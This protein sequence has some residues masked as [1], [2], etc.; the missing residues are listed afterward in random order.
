MHTFELLC[1]THIQIFT[2]IVFM[3]Y[4]EQTACPSV[5]LYVGLKKGLFLRSCCRIKLNADVIL[6]FIKQVSELQEQFF[7][8]S[9]SNP[10][11]N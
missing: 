4:D 9:P 1:S 11:S 6:F 8:F 2:N 7:H 5:F 3:R 10:W